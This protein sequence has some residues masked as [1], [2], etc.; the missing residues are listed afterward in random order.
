MTFADLDGDFQSD[1]VVGAPFYK[2][3]WPEEGRVFAYQGTLIGVSNTL[4]W[5]WLGGRTGAR[6]GTVVSGA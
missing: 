2:S 4:A 6:F 5:S 1:V 3:S